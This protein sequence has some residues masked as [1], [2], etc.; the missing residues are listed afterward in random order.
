MALPLLFTRQQD[1][2]GALGLALN[3]TEEP[4]GYHREELDQI[5]ELLVVAR[6]LWMSIPE[7]AEDEPA[8]GRHARRSA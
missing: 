3:A 1:G 4:N 7:T 8:R 2:F 6:D 5:R